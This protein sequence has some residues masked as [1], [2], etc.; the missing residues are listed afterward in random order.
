M[1]KNRDD[2]RAGILPTRILA[3]V[4]TP[5]L[6]LAGIGVAP[7]QHQRTPLEPP[8]ASQPETPQHRTRLFLK[9]GSYQ[10]VLSFRVVGDRVRYRS[11][12]RDGENEEIPLS[13]VDLPATQAW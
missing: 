1:S 6:A 4:A 7:A 9:D 2:V 13:L 3:L 10:T 8:V 11:A 5:L 12:E